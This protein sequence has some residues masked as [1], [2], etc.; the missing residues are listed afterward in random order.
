MQAAAVTREPLTIPGLRL[1]VS[2]VSLFMNSYCLPWVMPFSS[3]V[4]QGAFHSSLP[5]PH[6][7]PS[8][9]L[10]PDCENFQHR[11]WNHFLYQNYENRTETTKSFKKDGQQSIY[12]KTWRQLLC[13]HVLLHYILLAQLDLWVWD[14]FLDNKIRTINTQQGKG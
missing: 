8:S 4:S 5:F 10:H 14:P 3:W 7:S 13:V 2:S 9:H 6:P 1:P 11:L 12:L